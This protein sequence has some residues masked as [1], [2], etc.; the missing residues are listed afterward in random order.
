MSARAIQSVAADIATEQQA[1]G[2]TILRSRAA[3]RDSPRSLGHILRW[4]AAT[5]P[6]R[7]LVSEPMP[8]GGRRQV[9]Y[10]EA[11]STA[12]S[13]AQAFLDLGLG[14]SA[15]VLVLSGNSVDHLMLNLAGYVVGVPIVPVSVAYSLR[16]TD[17]S[18]LRAIVDLVRPGLVFAEDGAQFAAAL[19]A[20]PHYRQVVGANPGAGQML[21]SDLI[22]TSPTGRV[23][24]AL[25]ATRP[26][27]VAKIMFTSGST[28]T[29]KGV[30]TTHGMLCANQQMLRQIWTFLDDEP[31][32]LT[33]WLPWSHTF[34]GSHNAHLA[35]YNGGSLHIDHGR[36]DPAEFWRSIEAMLE[37]PPTM[38]VNVP[39]GYAMLIDYL[40]QDSAAA[41]RLLSRVSLVLVA[42]AELP[43]PLL[44]RLEAIVAAHTDGDVAIVNSWGATETAPAATSTYGGVRTGI[45]IP[46]PGV[47]VK[48][49]PL[50]DGRHE[51]RVSGP[52]VTPGYL[53]DT[54]R[55]GFDEEGFYR[56][57]DAVRMAVAG[58]PE[59]GLVYD[60]RLSE[61]FKLSTGTWVNSGELR[62][63]LLRATDLLGEAVIVGEK[64][65][66]LTAIVWLA[67]AVAAVSSSTEPWLLL[68]PEQSAVLSDALAELNAG[69]G[70]SGRIERLIVAAE[71]PSLDHAEITD[72][73]YVN[74]NM[75]LSR[76]L[77]LLDLL[78][79][80]EAP[81]SVITA[82][83]GRAEDRVRSGN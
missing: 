82:A 60:G 49:V 7:V 23:D 69:H 4:W 18:R 31:P 41:T 81:I 21:L 6:N 54:T 11:A 53:G 29:P 46:L 58:A 22:A 33:D 20:V 5:T 44:R 35:L 25:D 80:S 3:L 68:E 1:D 14:A 70:S 26:D 38:L 57:G 9:T 47:E 59:R 83:R 48:L 72:K 24:S 12:S 71:P 67:P 15:P 19:A 2:S 45:G 39:A 30:V 78:Y 40:E 56:T 75:V 43:V 62:R 52:N 27:T 77:D 51:I 74:R 8:T 28:G 32:I 66:H 34:G 63:R 61:D 64:Q 13:L 50:P 16:S 37:H 36:P 10:A 17:H 55:S 76:R 65:S 79:Q 42:A 73:G